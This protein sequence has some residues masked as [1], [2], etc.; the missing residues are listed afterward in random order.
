[1]IKHKRIPIMEHVE[2]YIEARDL[3]PDYC[4]TLRA[5]VRKF[6]L[7]I[8]APANDWKNNARTAHT[9]TEEIRTNSSTPE[10]SCRPSMRHICSCGERGRARSGP[11][12]F[13]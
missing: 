6:C 9:T 13:G 11:G 5:R 3:C 4:Q 1:M 10:G 2:T 8:G 12:R 7:Y